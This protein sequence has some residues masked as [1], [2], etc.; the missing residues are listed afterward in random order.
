[1]QSAAIYSQIKPTTLS[2]AAQY[3]QM[4]PAAQFAAAQ[5][6]SVPNAV[7]AA[8]TS[9]NNNRQP[10]IGPGQQQ[11]GGKFTFDFQ[12]AP[13]GMRMTEQETKGKTDVDVNMGYRSYA[14]G[15]P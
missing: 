8:G 10:L 15:A 1:V 12:N 2:V 3:P 9:T 13:P 6:L 4:Q 11:L 14:T 5:N 7:A